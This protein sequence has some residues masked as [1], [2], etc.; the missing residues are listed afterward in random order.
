MGEMGKELILA[1][2]RIQPAKL[3]AAGYR[4]QFPELDHALQHEKSVST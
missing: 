2:R 4:F 1:S 3:L